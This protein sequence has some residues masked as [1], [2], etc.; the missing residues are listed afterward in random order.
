MKDTTV[1]LDE[2]KLIS[3][4]MVQILHFAESFEV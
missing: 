1:E 2:F 3:E 4:V